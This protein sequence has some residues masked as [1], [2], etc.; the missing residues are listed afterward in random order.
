MKKYLSS[1]LLSLTVLITASPAF[2]GEC[3][4]LKGLMYTGGINQGRP[5]ITTL[6]PTTPP[7]SPYVAS[8]YSG[9][10]GIVDVVAGQTYT[11]SWNAT[12]FVY[13]RIG[14]YKNRDEVTQ[15]QK[16]IEFASFNSN[17][18]RYTFT[19]PDEATVATLLFA[20]DG[21][22]SAGISWNNV[23]IERG[24]TATSYIPYNPLC[25]TCQG[26]IKTY[27]SAVGTVAQ[28]GTPSPTNPIEPVFYQQGNM[29]LR[30]VGDYADSYDATTGKITRRVGVKVLNGTENF[31]YNSG[32]GQ[33][34][35]IQL[36]DTSGIENMA[37]IQ[38]HGQS[39]ADYNADTKFNIY[40]AGSNRLFFV[41]QVGN[42]GIVAGTTSGQK[43]QAFKTWLAQQYANGTPVTVYYPL[44]TEITEDVGTTYCADAIKIATTAYNSAR[45]SQVKTDLNSAVATIRDIVTKTINQTAAIASLQAD[46][47][48]R[49]EDAC[50]AGK[51][52]LLVETEE[53]GVIVPHWFPIIEA[54]E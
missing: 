34:V 13:G 21:N 11:A 33:G 29:I 45:F 20:A 53:N 3:N 44:K 10:A 43:V 5:Y 51:K 52:C 7:T 2:A 49:P 17:A 4:L 36:S 50:P 27:E 16:V 41:V 9:P 46:K 24:S 40:V 23:Q 28:N 6:T 8:G 31:V 38:T 19:V 22:G 42:C 39:I 18:T 14:F 12:G 48:T 47:Q 25:A 37:G 26:I 1:L 54:P 32:V 15:N 35:L 30:K